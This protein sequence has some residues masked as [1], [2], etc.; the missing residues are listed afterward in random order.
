[1]PIEAVQ[2][3]EASVA[4]VVDS[5]RLVSEALGWRIIRE[6]PANGSLTFKVPPTW[7]AFWGRHVDI[8]VQQQGEFVL[9]VVWTEPAGPLSLDPTREGARL[10]RRFIQDLLSA[11]E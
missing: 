2:S 7:L 6:A 5:C 8:S 9:M 10:A 1:M 3:I 11:I 4:E